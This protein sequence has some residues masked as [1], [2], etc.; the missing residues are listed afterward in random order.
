M[1][2]SDMIRVYA[3]LAF[4]IH[5][6]CYNVII[7]HNTMIKFNENADR[8]LGIH[9]NVP[10]KFRSQM[11]SEHIDAINTACNRVFAL[12]KGENP[13]EL[14]SSSDF[15]REE[16]PALSNEAQGIVQSDLEALAAAG[17]NDRFAVAQTIAHKLNEEL[18]SS[19]ARAN[20]LLHEYNVP[21]TGPDGRH[22]RGFS[23]EPWGQSI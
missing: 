23:N 16:S 8:G 14:W 19:R 6:I 15:L 1:K 20:Q 5:H 7:L 4:I 10:G 17:E 3:Y 13:H 21:I 12:S 2:M 22:M 18:S 11:P 9:S